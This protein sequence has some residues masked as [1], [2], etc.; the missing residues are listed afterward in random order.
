[1][2]QNLSTQ[3][4]LVLY[5]PLVYTIFMTQSTVFKTNKTQ[6]VRLPK[7]LAFPDS[8]KKVN[9]TQQ[10][11][12]L[13]ITPIRTSWVEFMKSAGIGD[14]FERLPQP[15]MQIREDDHD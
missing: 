14:D 12:S 10:G 1:M 4:A 13:V 5:T 2:L 7:A 11:D 8:V 15:P 6:A 3:A 9:I